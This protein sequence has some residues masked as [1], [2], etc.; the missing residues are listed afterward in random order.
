MLVLGVDPGSEEFLALESD[1][2]LHGGNRHGKVLT[3]SKDR[4]VMFMLTGRVCK[5]EAM[6]KATW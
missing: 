5:I 1:H 6:N 2:D 3:S 4:A